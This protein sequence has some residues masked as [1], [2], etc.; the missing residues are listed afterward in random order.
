M[1]VHNYRSH[2]RL[3]ELPSRLY[4]EDAL[5]ASADP[6]L[7]AAPAWD[8]LQDP[9]TE[10]LQSDAAQQ[11]DGYAAPAGDVGHSQL[12]GQHH[13]PD[14][15]RLQLVI[16][17]QDEGYP[18]PAGGD[19][20]SQLQGQHHYSDADRLQSGITKQD[21][22]YV[23]PAGGVGDTHVHGQHRQQYEDTPSAREYRGAAVDSG[24]DLQELEGRGFEPV[25]SVEEEE[26]GGHEE[27][28]YGDEEEDDGSMD[29]LP[30]N[31]LLYGVRGQ[32]VS[33]EYLA[34]IARFVHVSL[35]E[36]AFQL[37]VNLPD[38]I[39]VALTWCCSNG[40]SSLEA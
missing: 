7:V 11:D 5:V 24:R 33:I 3:L 8:E 19:G 21:E 40:C 37:L 2:S 30:V 4:Y 16:T 12:Q 26:H 34:E 32:Q 38:L 14:A 22:G 23:A 28:E 18:A 17:Q 35:S 6:K 15:D 31:T 36:L 13:R 20:D 10:H 25:E 29:Q 9:D 27:E 39:Q 1:L